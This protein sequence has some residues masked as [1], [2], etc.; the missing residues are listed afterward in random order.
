MSQPLQLN[1]QQINWIYGQEILGINDKDAFIQSL[2]EKTEVSNTNL[3]EKYEKKREKIEKK[4]EKKK[5]KLEKKYKKQNDQAELEKIDGLSNSLEIN[6]L[7][8]SC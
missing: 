2:R 1:E 6:N 3:N 8:S 4:Y 7:S 5:E